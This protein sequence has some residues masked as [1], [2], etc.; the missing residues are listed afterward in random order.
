MIKIREARDRLGIKQK[1]LA[2]KLGIRRPNLSRYETGEREPDS[3]TVRKIATLLNC[4]IDY[5]YGTTDDP[6]PADAKK[7][8]PTEITAEAVMLAAE[9][10]VGRPLTK[11][12][13]IILRSRVNDLR[14]TI[15]QIEKSA[16]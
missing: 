5:L 1:E 11:E 2:D 10:K 4:S 13:R 16:Q 14:A 9:E 8:A 15:E 7:E 3:E 12:E 6:T